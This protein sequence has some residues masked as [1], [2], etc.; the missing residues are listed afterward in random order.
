MLAVTR[1]LES[2]AIDDALDLFALL[3]ASR[4]ISPARRKSSGDRLTMLPKLERASRLLSR[5]GRVLIEQLDLV[6]EAGA[7]LDPAALWTAVIAEA[8]AS[9]EQ[10]LAALE[11]V[12]QLVPDDDGAA[13]AALRALLSATAGIELSA[14]IVVSC[15]S[16][17]RPH[18]G[19]PGRHDV[20]CRRPGPTR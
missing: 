19:G 8:G 14:I 11:Q 3:M 17:R 2:E 16:R 20:G 15:L 10:V 6:A 7:D 13:E 4:L 18:A 9:K 1:S 5:A 12:D